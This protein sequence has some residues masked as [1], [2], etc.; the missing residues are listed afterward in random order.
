MNDKLVFF[1]ASLD[2]PPSTPT[3]TP[4]S[5]QP[6]PEGS[7]VLTFVNYIGD[8]LTID[9]DNQLYTIPANDRLQLNLV[10]A[11]YT[12]SGR[13]SGDEGSNDEVTV[14]AGQTQVVGARLKRKD[15]DSLT[16]EQAH[17]ISNSWPD[18]TLVELA[19]NNLRA[20]LVMD[21]EFFEA[22]LDPAS[23]PSPT[24]ASPI[25]SHTTRPRGYCDL[26]SSRGNLD[27]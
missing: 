18:G 27:G 10:P 21:L 1:E 12:Y 6:P 24:P 19:G 25:T 3:P 2:P 8:V 23:Q 7:G 5:V 4:R 14:V 16:W 26:Q 13:V 15:K 20:G 17:L 11:R 9:I 22:S